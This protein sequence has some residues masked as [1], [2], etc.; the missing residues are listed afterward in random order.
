MKILLVEDDTVFAEQLS[1][2]LT[3]YNYLIEAVSD[4]ESGWEYVHATDYDLIVLDVQLPGE[5]GI[6]LCK[7]LRQANY[8]SAI[9]LL[10]ASSDSADKVRGLDAGADDYVVKPCTSEELCARIRAL[11]RRPREVAVTVLQYGGL[12]LDP[13]TCEV[14]Y[15]DQEI[16]LSPKEYGL[17]ELFLRNPHRIFSSG[18]LLEKLWSF[19]ETPGEETIRTHIKRL[20]RKLKRAGADQVIENVYGMGYRLNS[21]LAAD[22]AQTDHSE[23]TRAELTATSDVTSPPTTVE[24]KAAARSAAL[25][26]MSQFRP[27]FLERLTALDQL[28]EGLAL[29]NCSEPLRQTAKHAAHKLIGSLGMFGLADGSQL[30][31]EIEAILPPA[32]TIKDADRHRL[33]QLVAQ[34]HQQL[35]PI[36]TAPSS[37]VSPCPSQSATVRSTAMAI[38]PESLLITQEPNEFTELQAIAPVVT[39]SPAQVDDRLSEQP[40]PDLILLDLAAFSEPAQGLDWLTKLVEQFPK[41]P[42]FILAN[43]DTFQRRLEVVRCGG[44]CTYLPRTLPPQKLWDSVSFWYQEHGITNPHVLAVDDDPVMLATLTHQLMGNRYQVTTLQEPQQF[45]ES[46]TAIRPDLLIVDLEMPEVNGIELCQIIRADINWQHLPVI[47]LSGRQDPELIQM[48]YQAGADDYLIKP[49]SK[50]ELNVRISNRIHRSHQVF[51]GV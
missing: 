31:R 30:C 1:N 51:T 24:L 17:L 18:I 35:D 29:G 13:N 50:S 42:V 28:L 38:A 5:D 16:T 15:Q 11:L 25:A 21:S 47:F 36:L 22:Y 20:R 10:T 46:L 32:A 6:S 3:R 49:V 48:A 8:E 39:L 26:A 40:L 37:T 19:E 45:W 7:K 12:R 44:M 43:T 23:T 14:S 9:L 41:L 34:L 4:A 2:N 33:Q 27:D